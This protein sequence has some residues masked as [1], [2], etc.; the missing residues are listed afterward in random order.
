MTRL[1]LDQVKTPYLLFCEADT[2]L[3]D[4]PIEWDG[5][6]RT[7]ESGW[8]DL[9]RFHHLDYGFIHPSHMHLM[10]DQVRQE[11]C[12]IK[13]MRT[14]QWSQRPH[15]ASVNLYRRVLSTLS[16]GCRCF[17]EDPVY[18][19]FYDN[20]IP[21]NISIYTPEDKSI[22]RSRDLNGRDGGEKFEDKQVF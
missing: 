13:C 22:K 7:I 1:A 10:I 11:V 21:Y 4:A 6:V 5:I 18:G 12:G 15:V 16:E 17:I 9:I 14:K 19:Q 2:P 20:K 3:C 8:T